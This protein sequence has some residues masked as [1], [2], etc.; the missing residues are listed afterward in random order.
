MTESLSQKTLEEALAAVKARQA[1]YGSPVPNFERIRDLWN[2][3]KPEAQLT[4]VDVAIFSALIKIGRL[5]ETP[6]HADSWVDIA[7]Y[8]ACGREVSAAKPAAKVFDGFAFDPGSDERWWRNQ[9]HQ[10]SQWPS[11]VPLRDPNDESN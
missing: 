8:A 2:A 9:A 10:Q 3:Y 11:G 7:G 5:M 4:T 6:D 1:V